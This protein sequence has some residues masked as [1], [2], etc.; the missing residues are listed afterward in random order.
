MRKTAGAG[1]RGAA[2]DYPPLAVAVLCM[3]LLLVLL[4]SSL[5]LPQTNPSQTL[6]YAPVPPEDEDNP[7][8]A[9]NF[10]SL[11]LGSGRGGLGRG[12]AA[13]EGGEANAAGTPGGR[14]VKTASTKR[15]V[16][17]PPRQTEDA[18]APPCV[19][20]FNGD[21]GGATA[22]GVTPDEVRVVLYYEG[23]SGAPGPG[24]SSPCQRWIDLAKPLN[25]SPDDPAWHQASQAYQR[26]FNDRFQTYNRFVHFWVYQG[27]CDTTPEARRA[28]AVDTIQRM[29]PF[30]IMFGVGVSANFEAYLDE[31]TARGVVTFM[32]PFHTTNRPR[33]TFLRSP[34]RVWGHATTIEH[35]S[36]L[37]VDFMCAQIT[38]RPVAFS[39]N[40]ADQ[41]RE[42]LLGQLYAADPNEPDIGYQSRLIADGLRACGADIA[43]TRTSSYANTFLATSDGEAGPSQEAAAN[44]AEFKRRGVTTILLTGMTDITYSRAAAAIDY[45]PEWVVLGSMNQ[46]T[47][48]LGSL[49]D[50]SVW[51]NAVT[52]SQA[53]YVP[54]QGG[55]V[56]VAAAQEGDPSMTARQLRYQ[57]LYTYPPMRQIFTGIQLAGPKLTVAN[58]DRGFH[59]I[60]RV[61]STNPSVPACF[62][63]PRDYSCV[64]DAIAMW[65]DPAGPGDNVAGQPGCWRITEG[66]RRHLL[67]SW[68]AREASEL[69]DMSAACNNWA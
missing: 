51:R 67:G 43:V 54:Y 17:S 66:G 48:E 56:C 16:G 38:G 12:D 15:C 59:A 42:R 41:G 27:R 63:G 10:S 3:L 44:M 20:S 40:P 1:G 58:M 53:V 26:Y 35:Q 33:N 21:N 11:G 4:P 22:Q 29:D 31:V 5:N 69:R 23:S 50:A 52:I 68:P 25:D 64:K 36:D 45:R 8:P 9:G 39:G 61:E 55:Q 62:Y 28:D 57:C 37:F 13:V 2:R 24:D 19:P 47:N 14:V 7:P 49:Q 18:L 30:A 65:W 34:G 60:P 32:N 6:E 46:D